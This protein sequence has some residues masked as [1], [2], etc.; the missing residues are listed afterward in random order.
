MTAAAKPGQRVG[1]GT[2]N[3]RVC[4]HVFKEGGATQAVAVATCA[5]VLTRVVGLVG[6]TAL[7]SCVACCLQW[8]LRLDNLASNVVGLFLGSM[9]VAMRGTLMG[10]NLGISVGTLGIGARGCMECVIC[11]LS[12]VWDM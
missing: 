7:H 10:L 3:C 11:L 5:Q 9:V 12:L 6:V 4:E 2:P 1:G 8:R